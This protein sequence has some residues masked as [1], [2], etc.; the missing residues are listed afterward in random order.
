[1]ITKVLIYTF[2]L[3]VLIAGVGVLVDISQ[4][5]S[6]QLQTPVYSEQNVLVSIWERYKIDYIEKETFRTLDRSLDNITTSEGQSY[7]MLRA[8]W[9]DDKV[10]FNGAWQW[11]KD[12]LKKD[13]RWL[14]S[15]RFGERAD[16]TYGVQTEQGGE[17]SATDASVDIAL[18]L[19]LAHA[20]WDDQVYLI[21]AQKVLD[22]LWEYEV[23]L[24]GDAPYL[25]ANDVEKAAGKE[26]FNIN[27]SYYAPYAFRIF[28]E[29]D[30]THD[31]EGLVTSSYRVLN[32]SMKASFAGEPGELPPDWLLLNSE[33]GELRAPGKS[34]NYTTDYGYEALRIPWRIAM[35]YYWFE[36]EDAYAYLSTLDLLNREWNESGR[37][38]STYTHSG[39]PVTTYS[40]PAQY[41]AS[42]GYFSIHQPKIADQLVTILLSEY[43]TTSN[44]WRNDPGYYSNNWIWFGI[45]L[46]YGLLP[47]F[48]AEVKDSAI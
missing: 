35:D 9:M 27:P 42:L 38:V 4:P 43:D 5:Q 24:I 16:G 28:A 7:T 33:T 21:E 20:R 40:S 18:A 11:T 41:G 19:L 25:L 26:W 10:T 37:L 34:S 32:E 45:G 22:S 1:M 46:H 44:I 6:A 48:T 2:V 12:L 15:W 29:I 23:V 39:Q 30:P 14:F 17:N 31:W 8:V 47:N 3:L 13:D 36:S